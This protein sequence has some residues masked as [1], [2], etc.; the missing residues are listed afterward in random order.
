[1]QLALCTTKGVMRTQG[2]SGGFQ[3]GGNNSDRIVGSSSE[4]WVVEWQVV[5]VTQVKT[6]M[7]HEIIGRNN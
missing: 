3:S 1:M 4:S 7:R 2:H 6:W 5:V